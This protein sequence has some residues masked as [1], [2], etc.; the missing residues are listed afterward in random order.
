[1][2]NIGRIWFGIEIPKTRKNPR[3]MFGGFLSSVFRDTGSS[4]EEPEAGG[5]MA[6]LDL[7]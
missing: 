1:M 2:D 3:G 6:A 5:S 4:D 7:D